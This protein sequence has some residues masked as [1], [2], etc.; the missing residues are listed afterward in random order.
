MSYINHS[1][2]ALG[3]D[4]EWK[5]QGHFY[6][7]KTIDWRPYHVKAMSTEGYHQ[8]LNAVESAAKALGR[9]SQFKGVELVQ[10]NWFQAHH[11]QAIY[12]VSYIV[13]P[14]EEDFKG[15]V[16][17]TGKEIVVGGTG[18]AVEIGIQMGKPVYVYN[19]AENCWR[20]WMPSF[21]KFFAHEGSPILSKIFAGIGSRLLTPQGIQAIKDVY[22]KT[23]KS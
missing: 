6:G 4:R 14:G 12:A 15:F 19:M 22:K 7:V 1:G 23:F 2:G 18:W 13:P 9:P 17:E 21:N 11:A 3:A 8:M 10:R 20:K 16:N 5:D